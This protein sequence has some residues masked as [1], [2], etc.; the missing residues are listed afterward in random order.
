MSYRSNIS[1]CLT[2]FNIGLQNIKRC[3]VI[4][5]IANSKLGLRV[6]WYISKEIP[7][8]GVHR[9]CTVPDARV[10][11]TAMNPDERPINLTIPIGG[12]C[13]VLNIWDI[14]WG[15]WDGMEEKNGATPFYQSKHLRLSVCMCACLF[16]CLFLACLCFLYVHPS[17]CVFHSQYHSFVQWVNKSSQPTFQC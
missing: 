10:A 16:V 17:V 15:S 5:H 13:Q 14:K 6:V 1:K 4:S 11:C 3:R 8:E 12:R 7:K 2:Q 9:V